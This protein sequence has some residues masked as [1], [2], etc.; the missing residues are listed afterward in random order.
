MNITIF[1]KKY[2]LSII[3][4]NNIKNYLEN[5][6]KNKYNL[7]LFYKNDKIFRKLAFDTNFMFCDIMSDFMRE[8]NG[9]YDFNNKIISK[10]KFEEINKKLNKDGYFIENIGKKACDNIV[11]KI[12]NFKFIDRITNKTLNYSEIK[13]NNGYGNTF[14]INNMSDIINIKE[15]T[16]LISD[17]SILQI[18]QNYLGCNPILT[19]TN[20]W[21]SINNSFDNRNLS[22][23]AQLFHRDFDNEKWL[24]IF[25]YLNDIGIN[26][27]PHCY[28]KE[29]QD[30]IINNKIQRESDN[31]IN[32]NFDKKD[33]IYHC[34]EKG[35][36]IFE[37]T[38]GY[39][40]GTP[41][42]NG[43]RL[44]LQLEFAINPYCFPGCGNNFKIK[45]KTDFMKKYKYIFQLV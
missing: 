17:T 45:N 14:W 44:I 24:K 29:S 3:N 4:H 6:L 21:K 13:I 15:V 28:V 5:Y 42:I 41:V 16:D 22:K 38:R 35:T 25:V 34:G 33:I 19:Q 10:N 39:H 27:G 9:L 30:K 8:Y 40:K 26:N 37:N 43:E 1:L 11:N 32:N 2:D 12:Q 36:V 7:K 18:V 23:S 31:F 20:L